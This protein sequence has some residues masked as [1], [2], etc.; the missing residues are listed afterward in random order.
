MADDPRRRKVCYRVAVRFWLSLTY[1]DPAAAIDMARTAD[2]AGYH[3]V[4][5]SDHL[6]VPADL[7]SRYPYSADGAP[8]FSIDTQWPDPWCLVSAMAA[9]TERVRFT[10]N[11]YLAA[12]RPTFVVAKAVATAA[13]IAG[14]RVALGVGV[15]WMEEEYA[16]L[17]QDFHTRGRRLDEMLE[18][19]PLLWT[20]GTVEYHGRFHDFGPLRVVPAPPGPVPVYVGGDSA[21]ALRRAA[22]ADGWVGNVY[23]ADQV[24]DVV[25]RVR[26]ARESAGRDDGDGFQIVIAVAA[27]PD[28]DLY[29]RLEDEGVTAL[30]CAPWRRTDAPRDAV[31]R[32]ADEFVAPLSEG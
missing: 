9:V 3:S 7:R 20:G 14:G 22:S 10:T 25:G 16:H 2:E 31:L 1:L 21:P 19:L 32:F 27:P 15:G 5:L 30:I 8:P 11:V 4:T 17:G 13:A 24:G 18:V 26:R 28:L 29:R 6:L 12:A 23:P